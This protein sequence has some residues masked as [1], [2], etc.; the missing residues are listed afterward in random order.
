MA[1]WQV[2]EGQR[3]PLLFWVCFGLIVLNMVSGFTLSSK[4]QSLQW[5]SPIETSE[6]HHPIK[7]RGGRTTWVTESVAFWFNAFIPVQFGILA[8]VFLCVYIYRDRFERVA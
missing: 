8:L 4:I 3:V 5:S 7:W 6:Q 1:R 2:R